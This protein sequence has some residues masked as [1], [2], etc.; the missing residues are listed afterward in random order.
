M[1]SKP[2]GTNDIYGQ[3]SRIYQFLNETF[4]KLLNTYNYQEIIIPMFEQKDLFVRGVGNSTDIVSK[5]MYEFQD[6][7]NRTFVLRPEGTSGVVRAVIENKMYV[8]NQ[9]P[10][11][12]YYAGSMFRYERPQAG[13]SRE[14]NQFGI[15]AFGID[16]VEQDLEV[17]TI[18][19]DFLSAIE[20]HEHAE[21]YLNYLVTGKTRETYIH[22]LQKYLKTIP[23][24]CAD[25]KI[26]I[27]TNPLRVLDCKKDQAKLTNVP[28]MQTYLTKE[29]QEYFA[30]LT[31]FLNALNYKVIVDNK[32][33]RGLDYYTGVVFEIKNN[34]EDNAT[35]NLTLIAGGRYNKL[36][37]ELGG[38]ELP[39][40]GFA[41][42]VERI[43]SLLTNKPIQEKFNNAL[44]LYVGVLGDFTVE[45]WHFVN[46]L[47]VLGISV[48]TNLTK[49]PLKQIF[50]E[51]EKYHAKK[52]IILGDEEMRNQT[53]KIK[54]QNDGKEIK[55][56]IDE[57]NL[58]DLN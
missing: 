24:L 19:L 47:R 58:N 56:K 26:R 36:V 12:L 29:E 7:K 51:A 33:V 52:I 22:D 5:E 35:N 30:T 34:S 17:I 21:I 54:D 39:A 23:N 31:N 28:N 4:R 13:R 55:R 16:S 57:I 10:A 18:A 38:P 44:T 37:H 42:G 3:K 2:R 9:L 25:C 11:K 46:S 1:I 48:E 6:R 53:V 8:Q 43:V 15:E 49:V 40:V 27:K 45:K 41:L 20:L 50:K 14:F 32:L